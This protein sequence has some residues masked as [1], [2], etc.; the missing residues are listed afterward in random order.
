[1]H[2]GTLRC[3]GRLYRGIVW[4]PGSLF[5][6]ALLGTATQDLTQFSWDL[7]LSTMAA[8]GTIYGLPGIIVQCIW[9]IAPFQLEGICISNIPFEYIFMCKCVSWVIF[10]HFGNRILLSNFCKSR[11]L[12]FET[13]AIIDWLP[14]RRNETDLKKE[15]DSFIKGTFVQSFPMRIHDF[16]IQYLVFDR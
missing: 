13:N 9:T 12:K 16:Y 10:L 3:C 11:M 2:C 7:T 8:P 1:M 6:L 5:L 4:C 14:C 15:I